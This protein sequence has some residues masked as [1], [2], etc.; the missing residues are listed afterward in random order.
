MLRQ[1]AYRRKLA[2]GLVRAINDYFDR[3]VGA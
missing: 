3:I 2:G 1:A